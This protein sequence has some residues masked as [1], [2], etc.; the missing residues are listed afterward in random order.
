MQPAAAVLKDLDVNNMAK[1][2]LL[3]LVI[4]AVLLSVFNNFNMQGATQQVGYS[5]FVEEVNDD[6]VR[7][8]VVDG[9]TITAERYDGSTF[10]TIRPMVEDPKL[11][12]DLLSHKVEV[13]GR[14]PNSKAFGPSC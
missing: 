1:N 8:V 4:A 7:K 9:L 11:M 14:K 12:D 6:R 2:L 5:D 10:E 3:W 13:E